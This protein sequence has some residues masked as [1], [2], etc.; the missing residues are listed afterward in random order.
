MEIES[1]LD[2]LIYFSRNQRNFDY[3]V[4]ETTGKCS[5]DASYYLITMAN[6]H[7]KHI[8]AGLADPVPI[9]K[10]FERLR[11]GTFDYGFVSES[12]QN[13]TSAPVR[14]IN[15]SGYYLDGVL[16]LVDAPRTLAGI[17][18]SKRLEAVPTAI[19]CVTCYAHNAVFLNIFHTL[20][21]ST[22]ST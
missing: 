9:I 13:S 7:S 5:G 2:K 20:V 14:R 18:E 3:V 6:V 12:N 19:K 10:M 16:T 4:L 21:S 11:F 15:G 1:I 22:S 17:M 8:N